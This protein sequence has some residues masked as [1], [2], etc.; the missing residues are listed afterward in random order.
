MF[1]FDEQIN[2]VFKFEGK[3]H[4]I[5]YATKADVE[6]YVEA[7]KDKERSEVEVTYEFLTKLGADREVLEK[8]PMKCCAQLVEECLATK[9]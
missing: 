1:N 8:L 5:R 3:D 7:S 9:K 6:N 4:S 2:F